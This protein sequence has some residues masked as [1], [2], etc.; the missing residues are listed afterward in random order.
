MEEMEECGG[1]G[2]D[3]GREEQ[4]RAFMSPDQLNDLIL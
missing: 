2:G 4:P 1:G 3:G